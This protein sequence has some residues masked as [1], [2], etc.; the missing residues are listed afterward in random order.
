[1]LFASEV[2][3]EVVLSNGERR[4]FRLLVYTFTTLELQAGEQLT[5]LDLKSAD[6]FV[7]YHR[8]PN[9]RPKKR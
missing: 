7:K 5:D 8:S 2:W 3:G 6:A 9:R 1:M 4:D